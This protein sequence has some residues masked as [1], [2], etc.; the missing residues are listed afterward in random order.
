MEHPVMLEI[1]D[2]A[3]VDPLADGRLADGGAFLQR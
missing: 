2:V 1:D 3:C